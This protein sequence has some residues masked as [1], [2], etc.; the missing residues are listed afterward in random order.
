V[1]APRLLGERE[2]LFAPQRARFVALESL[3]LRCEFTPVHSELAREHGVP[4]R[5]NSTPIWDRREALARHSQ[6]ARGAG[7]SFRALRAAFP[8]S[9]P[10]SV[11]FPVSS[12]QRE[13]AHGSTELFRRPRVLGSA[14]VRSPPGR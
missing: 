13:M 8:C 7:R 5:D 9:Y 2:P 14:D 6:L 10:S 12:S 1:G 4:V 11:A 3:S